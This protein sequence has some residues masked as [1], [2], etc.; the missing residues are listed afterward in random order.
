M[1]VCENDKSK[2]LQAK[3]HDFSLFYGAS[4]FGGKNRKS[5]DESF[6]RSLSYWVILL[7]SCG[8]LAF[9]HVNVCAYVPAWC[10]V[11]FVVLPSG[12]H[13]DVGRVE[14][15]QVTNALT[16]EDLF[17][18]ATQSPNNNPL[19]LACTRD[20]LQGNGPIDLD[21]TPSSEEMPRKW[22]AV[23]RIE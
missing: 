5:C 3:L 1:C 4:F 20:Q 22:H 21:P 11:V 17:T 10:Q 16:E 12:W 6:M 15:L 2:G 13:S 19:A 7:L 14:L 9:R 23:D 8:V 18:V